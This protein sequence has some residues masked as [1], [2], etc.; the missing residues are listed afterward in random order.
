[1]SAYDRENE[2]TDFDRL[3]TV[4]L[5]AANMA[6]AGVMYLLSSHLF[7]AVLAGLGLVVLVVAALTEHPMARSESATANTVGHE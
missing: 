6:A 1:V 2:M 7:T 5:V 4:S 3:Y